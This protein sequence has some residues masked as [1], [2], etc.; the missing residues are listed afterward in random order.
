MNTISVGV[1]RGGPSSE[2]DVSLKTGHTMLTSLPPEQFAVRDIY[3]DKQGT[4]HERGIPMRPEQILPSL[5]MALIGLHGAYGSNGE[6]QKLLEQYGVPYGGT[7]ST[8]SLLASHSAFAKHHAE[9]AGLKTPRYHLVTSAD[10]LENDTAE[11]VRTLLQPVTLKPVRGGQ[12]YKVSGYPSII[13]VL[14][15]LFR[16]G[17]NGVLVE[18]RVRGKEVSVG[19]IEHVRGEELYALPVLE[20]NAE[21][22]LCP[23]PL[24]TLTR[25]EL[26]G[27]ARRMHRALGL[28]HYSS[29]RFV[30]SP[31]G[32]YYIETDTLPALTPN[33]V[34]TEK[35]KSVGIS[36]SNF[37]THLAHLA[38]KVR[39]LKPA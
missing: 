8:G 19:L 9:E 32:I 6:V 35:L 24:P 36:L 14:E 12:A 33:S 38:L 26:M 29:S 28:R 4:W 34:F 7:D 1:L 10:D 20:K 17:A 30:V 22:F 3:I 21:R 15:T 13:S 37:F 39:D 16:E 31:G 27:S 2:H 25:D 5:D 23:A 18:E 11:I